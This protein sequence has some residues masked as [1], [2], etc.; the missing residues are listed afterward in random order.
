MEN[1]I[2]RFPCNDPEPGS[3]RRAGEANVRSAL[4]PR[5]KVYNTQYSLVFVLK[6]S[7]EQ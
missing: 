6:S 4:F 3:E 7:E 5:G 1:W 2:L